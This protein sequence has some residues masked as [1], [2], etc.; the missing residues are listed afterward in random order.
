MTDAQKLQTVKVLLEDGSGYMPT[1]ETLNTY[2]ALSG[3]E[4]L[5]WMYHLVGGVPSGVT[6]VPERYDG[7]QVYAVVAGW[8]HAGAEG[9]SVSIENGVHRHF[10]YADMLDYIHNHVLPFVRVGAVK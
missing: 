4:I 3:N 1:D 10:D 2:I 9:Q 7:T 5:S 8:T 6:D